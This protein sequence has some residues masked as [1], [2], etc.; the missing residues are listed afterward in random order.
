MQLGAYSVEG[1]GGGKGKRPLASA[2]AQRTFSAGQPEGGRLG[3]PT[4]GRQW[5]SAE[6]QRLPDGGWSELEPSTPV[7][8]V[9]TSSK[10]MSL[11][12]ALSTALVRDRR[13]HLGEADVP[14]KRAR[15]T[16]RPRNKPTD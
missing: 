3:L 11:F 16:E 12:F 6:A 13:R 7:L 1:E 5:L 8:H 14:V 9:L 4:S 2:L 15:L 10:R